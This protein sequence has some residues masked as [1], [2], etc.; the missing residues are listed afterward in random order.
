MESASWV[1]L[2]KPILYNNNNPNTLI[3]ISRLGREINHHPRTSA[4]PCSR[5]GKHPLNRAPVRLFRS[6]ETPTNRA[7]HQPRIC[8]VRFS[9]EAT[10]T[11]RATTQPHCVA[12]TGL[13]EPPKWA[14]TRQICLPCSYC[15]YGFSFPAR[16][17]IPLLV[18]GSNP[19]SGL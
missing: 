8:A 9:T 5:P 1:I 17:G 16:A 7:A 19:L 11:I 12:A 2:L 14:P 15:P 4:Q 6:E 3:H 10:P 18:G 13:Q